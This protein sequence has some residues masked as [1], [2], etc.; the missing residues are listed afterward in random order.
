MELRLPLVD[1]S[2]AV[3]LLVGDLPGCLCA[4]VLVVSVTEPYPIREFVVVGV[5]RPVVV[6]EWDVMDGHVDPYRRDAP[7]ASVP[8][9]ADL[10]AADSSDAYRDLRDGFSRYVPRVAATEHHGDANADPDPDR[11]T[12]EIWTDGDVFHPWNTR[13]RI[14]PNH[15]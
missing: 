7:W 11:L 15:W 2:H 9:G 6:E 10:S 13:N 3:L 5:V 4:L 12:N 1:A 14:R 8:Y